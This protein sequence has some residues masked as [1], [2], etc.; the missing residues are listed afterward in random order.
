MRSMKQTSISKVPDVQCMPFVNRQKIFQE[1]EFITFRS[2]LA[3][4]I[5]PLRFPSRGNLYL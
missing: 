5:E 4:V 3:V 1:D 2:D